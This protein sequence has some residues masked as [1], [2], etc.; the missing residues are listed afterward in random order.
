MDG[1]SIECFI[2]VAECMSFTKAAIKVGRT[3]SAITQQIKSLELK[4]GTRLFDREKKVTLTKEGELLLPYAYKIDAIHQE[5]ID[6]FKNPELDGEA[7]IGVPEDFATL[8]LADVL[9]NF[10]RIHPRVFLKVECDLTWNLIQKFKEGLLD[11]ALIKMSSPHEFPHGVDIWKEP[12][13][14]VKKHGSSPFLKEQSP[15][16]LI[17]SPEPCVYRSRAITALQKSNIQWRIVYTSPSYA[18]I[19]AAVKA[20]MGM[21]V[22]PMTMIPKGLEIVS[23]PNLPLLPD[24]HVSLLTRD[25][26]PSLAIETL[27]EFLLEKLKQ[28]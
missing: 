18:G 14:W 24:I 17:L 13:V 8:F 3:Q 6:R 5:I 26:K 1:F 25:D 27:S 22:L 28:K 10:S 20:N 12:V 9:M 19:I 15:I 2:A 21:T 16:P 11:V 7:R 23:H 4:L